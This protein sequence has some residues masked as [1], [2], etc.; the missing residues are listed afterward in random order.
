MKRIRLLKAFE[1]GDRCFD[2]LSTYGQ[3]L[4]KASGLPVEKYG[5]YH[6]WNGKEKRED[7]GYATEGKQGITQFSVLPLQNEFQKPGQGIDKAVNAATE[8]QSRQQIPV[9]DTEP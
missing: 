5:K 1:Y 4:L 8:S 3:T 2:R 7:E 6:Q 9:L